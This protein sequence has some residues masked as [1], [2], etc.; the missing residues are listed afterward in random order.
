LSRPADAGPPGPDTRKGDYTRRLERL[1]GVWWKRLLDVQRPYRWNLHRLDLGRTLDIVCGL[2]RN[3]VAL[4]VGSIGVDH[5]PTSV[6]VARSRGL[7]AMT[8]DEFGAT[9][10]FRRATFDSL[11]LA[12]V[13]EHMDEEAGRQLVETYLPCLRPRG[14]VVFIC[15]Q[16]RGYASDPTHVR[17]VN[18]GDLDRLADSLGLQVNGRYSFPFP[19]F[20]GRLFPHNEF[21]LRATTSS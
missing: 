11:L 15:P 9:E 14:S 16:E 17:F 2:G 19:R 12:H 20:V 5:N 1:E 21:V 6:A 18:F 13:I 4:A 10:A 3:L 8:P 7:Q